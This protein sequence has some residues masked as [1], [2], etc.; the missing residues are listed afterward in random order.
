MPHFQVL[1]ALLG[2]LASY[3]EDQCRT[4][5]SPILWVALQIS[6]HM[7]HESWSR[8]ALLC[9]GCLP[10]QFYSSRYFS[11]FISLLT[12]AKHWGISSLLQSSESYLTARLSQ[13]TSR[14]H[15]KTLDFNCFR[16]LLLILFCSF[17][18]LRRNCCLG[19]FGLS[20]LCC[21]MHCTLS[22]MEITL[23]FS[24]IQLKYR[25]QQ[26]CTKGHT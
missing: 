12:A 11:F 14:Y 3:L 15:F 13:Q 24:S 4:L 8:S 18:E 20:S 22:S 23:K 17:R 9:P 10:R 25:P 21:F 7:D 6:L 16:S 19:P 26:V 1:C 2:T 5:S